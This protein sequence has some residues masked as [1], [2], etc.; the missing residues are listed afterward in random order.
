MSLVASIFLNDIAPIFVLAAVGFVLARR[1]GANVR[2]L[3]T[4]SFNALSPC[5][6]FDQLVTARVGLAQSWRVV[7]FCVLIVILLYRPSGLFGKH[8]VE[9][10]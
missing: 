2:T 6:V 9:K 7:A 10:V 8:T 3:S 4:I 5:L 1:G